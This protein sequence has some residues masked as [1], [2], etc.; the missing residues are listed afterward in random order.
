[1]LYVKDVWRTVE[2]TLLLFVSVSYTLI[3]IILLGGRTCQEKRTIK[4]RK[5][6][7]RHPGVFVIYFR[8]C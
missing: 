7:I 8:F 3:Q 6:I 5:F 2:G 4:C 1:V